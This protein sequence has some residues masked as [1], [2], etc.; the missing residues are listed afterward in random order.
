MRKIRPL[1]PLG[2]GAGAASGA[3]PEPAKPER[4][5]R[6]IRLLGAVSP[7]SPVAPAPAA[8]VAPA[9]VPSA[10]VA[11]MARG[12]VD[13]ARVA[14]LSSGR[15]RDVSGA[16]AV[17]AAVVGDIVSRAEIAA[18]RALRV[19]SHDAGA[20]VWRDILESLQ[21]CGLSPDIFCARSGRH[22]QR[23]DASG[24]SDMLSGVAALGDTRQGDASRA[25]LLSAVVVQLGGHVLPL[26]LVDSAENLALLRETSPR[27]FLA[28]ALSRIFALPSRSDALA[29]AQFAARLGQV[30]A[31][32]DSLPR[33]VLE[34]ACECVTLYLSYLHPARLPA[35]TG[36]SAFYPAGDWGGCCASP[37]A[38]GHLCG[39]VV[40]V[41]FSF[42]A[43]ARCRPVDQLSARDLAALRVHWGCVQSFADC[44]KARADIR[45]G[46]SDALKL[47]RHMRNLSAGQIAAFASA[48]GVSM[49]DLVLDLT[50]LQSAAAMTGRKVPIAFDRPEQFDAA[51]SRKAALQSRAQ[52]LLGAGA[53]AGAEPVARSSQ[54]DAVP[55]VADVFDLGADISAL[56]LSGALPDDFAGGFDSVD[57]LVNGGV[58]TIE[59]VLDFDFDHI[60]G[61]SD[62]DDD[63]STQSLDDLQSELIAQ[64][65]AQAGS[66]S[67][68]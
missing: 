17:G 19:P 38:V 32:I 21:D 5:P 41:L 60:A 4:V 11:D 14:L 34:Y 68:G 27:D 65:M 45:G 56:M 20:A 55:D 15:G 25:R 7:V 42:I 37:A 1:K 43:R 23:L 18:R 51:Q 40:Q 35:D 36:L 24:W 9:A 13:R 52:S 47:P 64:A 57:D 58:M 39:R 12:A 31:G 61:A 30:R 53:G 44:R 8:P 33:A 59:D 3:G 67:L 16:G 10:S 28:V 46:V 6:K 50:D 66:F 26:V 29:R 62:D 54:S 48:S 63:E 2:D 49:S 22:V